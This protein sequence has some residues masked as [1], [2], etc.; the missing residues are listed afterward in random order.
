MADIVKV[1]YEIGETFKDEKVIDFNDIFVNSIHKFVEFDIGTSEYRIVDFD[2]I[3]KRLITVST[4]SKGG[5]LLPNL[6]LMDKNGLKAVWSNMEKNFSSNKKRSIIQ[7]KAL[8]VIKSKIDYEKIEQIKEEISKEESVKKKKDQSIYYLALKC[9]NRFISERFKSVY[10]HYLN[11]AFGKSTKKA[12]SYLNNATQSGA[13][14]GLNFCSLNELPTSLEKLTKWRL[15]PLDEESAKKVAHGFRRVFEKEEFKYRLFGLYYYLLP[16]V[17]FDD[18]KRFF[19][20]L[21]QSTKENSNNLDSK[22]ILERRLENLVKRL[23]EA[24]ISQKVLFTFMFAQKNNNEIKLFQTIEDVAPSRITKATHAMSE[25]N[26]DASN[27]SKYIKTNEYDIQSVYLKDY[28]Y[29]LLF[30]AKLLLGKEKINSHN[31][32]YSLINKKILFGNQGWEYDFSKKVYKATKKNRSLTSILS[33]DTFFDKH[34]EIN[35]FEDDT[36]FEKHQRVLDFLNDIEA[37][38]CDTTNLVY[39]GDMNETSS[40][41]ALMEEKFENVGLLKSS[42]AKEFYIVGALARF[43]IAWQYAKDSDTV[44][45]YIDS[46][47]S[48]NTQNIDRVFRKIYD[49]SRK[50]SMYGEE[51]DALMSAYSQIKSQIKQSDNLSI[52]KANIAFVMGNIDYKNF[53]PKSK[54]ENK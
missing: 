10:F 4:S 54:E 46:I 50:Y 13:D 22:E 1:F 34:N 19:A 49:G 38:G 11:S 42:R 18:K 8:E 27:L 35:Y 24:H 45:K 14:A 29:D 2:V 12:Q 39:G 23:E 17:F 20:Q 33:G 43:V 21:S 15:L 16:T 37:L 41:K 25:F 28:I 47:G 44:A 26:I 51:F 48:I 6:P 7:K 31:E 52:D 30:L 5:Y 9:N 3:A 36:N 53:K 40:F 32:I